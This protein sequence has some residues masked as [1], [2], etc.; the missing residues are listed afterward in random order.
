[1]VV[2]D[3]DPRAPGFKYADVSGIGATVLESP[4][5]LDSMLTGSTSGMTGLSDQPQ[6]PFV[7]ETPKEQQAAQATIE[8]I[9]HKYERK[10]KRGVWQLTEPE[11]RKEIAAAVKEAL[12]PV[13]G[14]LE[15][16]GDEPN[17]EK[18]VEVVTEK[19]VELTED[20]AQVEQPPKYEGRVVT[21]LLSPK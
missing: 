15:G 10:L 4:T 14:E 18:I 19:L 8:L 20:F 21:M 5:V 12:K 6:T 7:F 9:Q 3:A 13:Q 2:T 1:M 17:Y 11:V 16:V